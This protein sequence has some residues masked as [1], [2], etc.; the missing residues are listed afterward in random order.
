MERGLFDRLKN[1][2]P[3]ALLALIAQCRK[4]PRPGKI[5]LGVG[6]YRDEQGRTPVLRA[7]KAAE[8]RL[9]ET[10]ASK[11]YLGPEG[12]A[13][14]V[15]E[16]ATLLFGADRP[17]KRLVGLQTPG[18]TGALRLAAELIKAAAPDATVWVGTPTWPN[19]QPILASAGLKAAT[20]RYFD[21]ASQ[22]VLFDEMM[23]ALGGA[24]AGDVALLH[25]CCHN[26]TGGDLDAG[27]WARVAE[28]LAER[29]VLPV[30]DLA[31]HGLGG[32]LEA[33]LTGLRALTARIGR[34]LVAQSCDKNFGLYRDRT[35]ALFALCASAGE[36]ELVGSNLAALARTNW[37]MPP[38][39]GAAVARIVLE[40]PEL[41]ADW[42]AEL[43][44]MRTRLNGVRAA[45]AAASPELAPL[46]RQNGM[47]SLLPIGPD[48][49]AR[50]REEHAIYMAG[51]GRINIAG[52]ATADVDRFVKALAACR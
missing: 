32:G 10:Q 17:E 14:F 39:H 47:F 2:P 9:L 41:A 25:G 18:G 16:I 37:S 28:L 36:A 33:D 48:V 13:G 52:L 34:V 44:E 15:R 30:L 43:E 22:S 35:G 49:V 20:Y 46:G 31:Y 19:H 5:D 27:Q 45:L 51:S 6:V 21:V 42:R 1:Q 23:A 8:R 24:K 12:D 26:P 50:L 11:S 3:D 38:D 4:D 29:G 7:V 40:T